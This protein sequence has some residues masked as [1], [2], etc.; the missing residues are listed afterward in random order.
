[1]VTTANRGIS[2]AVPKTGDDATDRALQ[3]LAEAVRRLG[4]PMTMGTAIESVR[5]TSSPMT[6]TLSHGFGRPYQGWFVTRIQGGVVTS[7]V[8]DS[9]PDAS[10]VLR[11]SYTGS[12]DAELDFWVY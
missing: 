11:L 7:I 2:I 5:P 4:G 12:V 3:V 10:R 1:M 6:L 8:E 9:S